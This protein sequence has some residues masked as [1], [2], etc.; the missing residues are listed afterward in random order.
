MWLFDLLMITDG[1][2]PIKIRFS[3]GMEKQKIK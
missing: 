1:K 2:I 3:N